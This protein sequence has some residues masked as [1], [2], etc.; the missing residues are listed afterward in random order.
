MRTHVRMLSGY[1]NRV[2]YYSNFSMYDGLIGGCY[3]GRA[4]IVVETSFNV[5][6]LLRHERW[7]MLHNIYVE[8]QEDTSDDLANS[9]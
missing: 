4:I 8:T 3:L 2:Y 1:S 5:M 9:T 7:A 6:L